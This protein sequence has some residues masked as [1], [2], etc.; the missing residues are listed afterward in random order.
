[1]SIGL[2]PM[3]AAMNNIKIIDGYHTI[4]SLEYKKR[5]RKIISKELDKNLNLKNYYDNWG[6]RLY[7]FY[8]DKNNVSINFVEA[9]NLG[10]DYVLSSFPI[11]SSK[12]ETVCNSCNQNDDLYLYKIL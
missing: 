1:M 12:L 8:N 3:V 10:A 9:K 6:S 5:F 2:D 7:V 4:Y 11:T